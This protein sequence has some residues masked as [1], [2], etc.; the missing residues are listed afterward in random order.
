MTNETQNIKQ[1]GGLALGVLLG[2]LFPF[3]LIGAIVIHELSVEPEN[4]IMRKLLTNAGTSTGQMEKE[5]IE[6]SAKAEFFQEWLLNHAQQQEQR[7]TV[8]YTAYNEAIKNA[9]NTAMEMD[10]QALATASEVLKSSLGGKAVISS[11]SDMGCAAA[12]AFKIPEL[13]G[14]CKVGKPIRKDIAGEIKFTLEHNRTQMFNSIMATMPSAK[15]FGVKSI[16][17]D[18]ILKAFDAEMKKNG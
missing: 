1:V 8:A 10:R 7:Q 6:K 17:V 16:N 15:E 2:T 11:I 3:L 5:H 12:I 13:A 4:T 9:M 18:E 14:T